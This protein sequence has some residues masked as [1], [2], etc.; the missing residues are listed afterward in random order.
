MCYSKYVETARSHEATS[1]DSLQITKKG[2]RTMEYDFV[3]LITD[4]SQGDTDYYFM[5][6]PPT[7]DRLA[8]SE[9]DLRFVEQALLALLDLKEDQM[10]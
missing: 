8:S 4:S 2:E 1:S 6:L 7:D 10:R 9:L 5:L 3:M